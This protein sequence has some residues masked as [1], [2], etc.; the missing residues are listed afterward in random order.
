MICS[1]FHSVAD[2]LQYFWGSCRN[3]EIFT[4][5]MRYM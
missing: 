4:E 3:A 2:A 5:Q 1:V